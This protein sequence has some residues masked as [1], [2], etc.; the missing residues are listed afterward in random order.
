MVERLPIDTSHG[1]R[2]AWEA[3]LDR[4][5]LRP[6]QPLDV[7]FGM[8]DD[9]EL[10]ATAARDGHRIKCVAIDERHRGGADFHALLSAL[11]ADAYD[12]RIDRL[13]CY[14]TP[15]AVMAF[16]NLGFRPIAATPEGITFLERGTPDIHDYIER[17]RDENARFEA[18]HGTPEGP[19]ESIV[20]NANP[21]T[22]GHRYLIE[23][24]LTRSDR[25]HLFIVS[26]DASMF[27][28]DVRRRLV[29]EGTKDLSGI[30]YHPTDHYIISRA[31]FPAYFLKRKDDATETQ[32]TLDAIVFR[33]RIAPALNITHRTVGEEPSD[34]VTAIYN[35][36]LARQ[37]RGHLHLTRTPRL[38]DGDG[39]PISASR[40]R[41][42]LTTGHLEPLPDLV[43][44]TTLDYL[45][46][47][48]G[49]A[50]IHAENR[51]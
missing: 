4:A 10:I 33:D 46:S 1:T 18:L 31:S 16:K 21:F 35:D 3:L 41:R 37:F 2:D 26:E 5:G 43:P 22:R 28:A 23:D 24:A 15:D 8:Y 49:Q 48:A 38:T 7:V 44:P 47:D 9:G 45:L 11:I 20:M 19:V 40:V 50:Q 36:C 14:T 42:C 29:I 51:P 13:F 12:H 17:L 25:L 27:P 32:A 30:V 34:V 6:E 39:V